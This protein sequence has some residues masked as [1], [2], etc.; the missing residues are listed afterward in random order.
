MWILVGLFMLTISLF[1]FDPA[2]DLGPNFLNVNGG[3]FVQPPLLLKSLTPSQTV[4]PISHPS[5]LRLPEDA[6]GTAQPQQKN[7]IVMPPPPEQ[8]DRKAQVPGS[9]LKPKA[10]KTPSKNF[11]C[12]TCNKTFKMACLLTRHMPKHTG[13][14]FFKCSLCPK[15]CSEKH[16]VVIHLRRKAH[17]KTL[18]AGL[19]N[20]G[21]KT[22]KARNNAIKDGKLLATLFVQDL[23]E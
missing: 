17:A 11:P 4:S 15:K 2:F 1:A 21:Y 5:L 7:I 6:P 10:Q 22:Q 3:T 8:S 18:M 23:R 14:T 9:Q 16:N 12:L 20:Q 19:T 13:E